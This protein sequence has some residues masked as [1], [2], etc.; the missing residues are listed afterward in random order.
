MHEQKK[1]THQGILPF[2]VQK[3]KN[4]TFKTT[5]LQ[6]QAFYSDKKLGKLIFSFSTS[7]FLCPI[8]TNPTPRSLQPHT[9]TKTN[10]TKKPIN[11]YSTSFAL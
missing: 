10:Q 6:F 3:P 11:F 4:K 2:N 9:H 7:Q 8:S 5:F 1:S